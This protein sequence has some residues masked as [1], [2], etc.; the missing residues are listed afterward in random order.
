MKKLLKSNIFLFKLWFHFYRKKRGVKPRY[1]NKNTK[2]YLDGYPRSGNTFA[3]SLIKGV[4]GEEVF[5]GHLHAIAPIKIA[6]KKNISVFIL[7]WCPEEAITS[8]YLKTYA[9][10]HTKIPEK[11]NHNLLSKLTIEYSDYYKFVIEKKQ[12]FE[13]IF[14]NDL[15]SAPHNFMDKIN[16]LVFNNKFE[17]N[18]INLNELISNYSGAK[19]TLGS[20]K[21][22]K[23]KEKI[24]KD[25]KAVLFELKEYQRAKSLYNKIEN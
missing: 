16:N 21:P 5:V 10:N 7:V 11:I 14:F 2:F 6:L 9:L 19:D 17:L 3:L 12:N 20:S 18:S 1:F 25:L 15:V 23:V 24:K 13:I 22:N 8:Y 4:F